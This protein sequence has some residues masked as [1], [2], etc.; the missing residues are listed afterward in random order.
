MCSHHTCRFVPAKARSIA[1]TGVTPTP[2]DNNTTGESLS[3]KVKSPRG[4]ATS[5]VSPSRSLVCRKVLTEPSRF[6]LIRYPAAVT[7]DSE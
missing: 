6:T 5:K 3:A 2:A 1:N 7:A 4:A